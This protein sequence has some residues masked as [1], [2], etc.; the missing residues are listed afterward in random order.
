LP[1]NQPY[2]EKELLFHIADGELSAMRMFYELYYS[3]LFY[4]GSTLIHDIPD[5]Q[6]FAQEALVS[7]WQKREDFRHSS[8]SQAEAFLFTVVRNKS[9]NLLRHQ[10]MKAGKEADMRSGPAFDEEAEARFI[11]EDVFDRVYK[12]IQELPA[13]QAQLLKMIFVEGL[14]TDE[15]AQKLAIT[16]NNVRNQKARALEKIRTL[17]LKKGLLF[18][19]LLFFYFLLIFL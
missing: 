19:F 17:I 18:F 10:K 8:L 11:Q 2:D 7:F 3:R 16:P 14:G 1:E 9:Y 4:F 13:A 15:I 12:E 6:D 5:A